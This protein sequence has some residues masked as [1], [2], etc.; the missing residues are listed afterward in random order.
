MEE[1]GAISNDI[2]G[3]KMNFEE[4]E[5]LRD[6]VDESF[7]KLKRIGGY[8]E[9]ELKYQMPP[10]FETRFAERLSDAVRGPDLE[11]WFNEL[12]HKYLEYVR[13][14]HLQCYRGPLQYDVRELF[15][16]IKLEGLNSL[17]VQEFAELLND[18][19]KELD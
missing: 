18:A 14:C 1:Q 3:P 17:V 5:R 7:N 9:Y 13:R 15:E 2:F 19:S 12:T 6:K 16:K 10:D 11:R 8:T 4:V